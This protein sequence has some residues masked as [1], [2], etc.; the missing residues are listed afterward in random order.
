MVRKGA[1]KVGVIASESIV[2]ICFYPEVC[3]VHVRSSW[4]ISHHAG[5][6]RAGL[7]LHQLSKPLGSSADRGSVS[8]L[9]QNDPSRQAQTV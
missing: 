3:H 1:G 8:C 2:V 4:K 9:Q 6:C 7:P 5:L